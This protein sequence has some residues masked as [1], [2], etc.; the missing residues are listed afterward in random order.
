MVLATSLCL[1]ILVSFHVLL[2]I[3]ISTGKCPFRSC[4][5]IL[6]SSCPFIIELQLF[7]IYYGWISYIRYMISPFGGFSFSQQ[8]P[9]K[10]KR[11]NFD[12]VQFI[13]FFLLHVLLVAYLRN[14]CLIQGHKIYDYFFL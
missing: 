12:D 4:V 7:C 10:H 9:L 14:Y 3:S 11:Q 5:F 13:Y 2:A 1:M 6:N 8:C